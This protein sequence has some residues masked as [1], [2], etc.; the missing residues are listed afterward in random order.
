MGSSASTMA[1]RPTMALAMATRWRW[2][3]ESFVG[4][5][6][7]LSARP[8]RI[9]AWEAARRRS[10]SEAPAYRRPSATLSRTRLVLGQEELLEDEADPRGP[11]RR[12]LTVCQCGDVEP[13]D[14]HPAGGRAV[15]GAHQMEEGRLTGPRRPDDGEQLPLVDGE[16]DPAQSLDGR[17]DGVGLCDPLELQDRRG[18]AIGDESARHEARERAHQRPSQRSSHTFG[19]TTRWPTCTLAPLTCTIPSASSN[20]PTVTASR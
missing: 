18:G 13:R 19:T 6:A 16:A 2:P 7:S 9:S 11:Q 3:P 15:E 5:E 20:R 10:A 1:G 12:Q 14:Q 4:K 8:T 17:L